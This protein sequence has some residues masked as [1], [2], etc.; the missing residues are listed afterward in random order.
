MRA[1]A[2]THITHIH[3]HLCELEVLTQDVGVD[4]AEHG[5]HA[6]RHQ[7]DREHHDA[8]AGSGEVVP[9]YFDCIVM[10]K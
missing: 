7:N 4:C 10:E 3:A 9:R 6:R 2:R 5:R 8:Y 1:R